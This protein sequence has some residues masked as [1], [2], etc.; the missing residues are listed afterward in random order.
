MN[1]SAKE[2]KTNYGGCIM[3]PSERLLPFSEKTEQQKWLNKIEQLKIKHNTSNVKKYGTAWLFFTLG[4]DG[5]VECFELNKRCISAKDC[6]QSRYFKTYIDT[7]SFSQA[8][9]KDH[10]PLVAFTNKKDK[11]T[12]NLGY[13]LHLGVRTTHILKIRNDGYAPHDNN[14]D[15]VHLSL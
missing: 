9:K 10:C 1:N 3:Q 15:V 4:N 5:T 13:V 11:S 2:T 8:Q 7:T 14:S 6:P 12:W